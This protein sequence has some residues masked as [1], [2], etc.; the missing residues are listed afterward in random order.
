[1]STKFCRECGVACNTEFC[2]ED[3]KYDFHYQ[4]E[5]DD[6]GVDRATELELEMLWRQ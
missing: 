3:C 1:M 4:N 5:P 2:S 6:D